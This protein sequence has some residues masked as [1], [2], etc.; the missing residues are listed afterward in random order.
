MNYAPPKKKKL[1]NKI[2][3]IIAKNL[4]VF[5]I[6]NRLKQQNTTIGGVAELV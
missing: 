5:Y 1:Q 3:Q 4:K 2:I 6:C